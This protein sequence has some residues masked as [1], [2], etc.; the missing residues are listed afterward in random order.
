MDRA[1]ASSNAASE[2][3]L[4]V[5][6]V[7]QKMIIVLI[8]NLDLVVNIDIRELRRK[9]KDLEKRSGVRFD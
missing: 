6:I 2:E 5:M 4:N 8:E 9:L 1:M 7:V 3:Q